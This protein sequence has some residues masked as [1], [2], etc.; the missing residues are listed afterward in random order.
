MPKVSIHTAIHDYGCVEY[1][2]PQL[3]VDMG[4][5]AI[6]VYLQ[7][8]HDHDYY[9]DPKPEC[10]D[11]EIS[12]AWLTDES[13]HDEKELYV[14]TEHDDETRKHPKQCP[15]CKADLATF[16]DYGSIQIDG[17]HCWQ[18]CCCTHC[19]AGWNE[20]YTA[21]G[22]DNLELPKQQKRPDRADRA[23]P[24]RVQPDKDAKP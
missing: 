18:E 3:V 9:I 8:E 17:K 21:S 10:G 13:G 6:Q 12:S 24:P 19:N 1:D 20:I 11:V 7:N 15:H 16:G 22:I 2:V 5:D 14:L 4:W 23:L